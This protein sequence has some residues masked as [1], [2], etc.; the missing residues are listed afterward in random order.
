VERLGDRR[1]PEGPMITPDLRPSDVR[2]R[3]L[4]RLVPD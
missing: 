4:V 1:E 3:I 2:Y